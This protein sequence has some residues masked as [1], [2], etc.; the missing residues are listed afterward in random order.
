MQTRVTWKNLLKN[1]LNLAVIISNQLDLINKIGLL[2]N[3]VVS[4]GAGRC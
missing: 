2:L 1:K 3:N 4:Y